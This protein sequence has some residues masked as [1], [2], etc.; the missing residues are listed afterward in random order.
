MEWPA[1]PDQFDSVMVAF[2]ANGAQVAS[3]EADA[4]LLH[5]RPE[6]AV[7]LMPASL[8]EDPVRVELA[9]SAAFSARVGV[10]SDG[11]LSL[12]LVQRGPLD[13]AADAVLEFD[14]TTVDFNELLTQQGVTS[15]PT[16]DLST[17][18]TISGCQAL[19]DSGGW[20]RRVDCLAYDSLGTGPAFVSVSTKFDYA[21]KSGGGRITAIAPNDEQCAGGSA[22]VSASIYRGTN[23]GSTPALGINHLT[24]TWNPGFPSS[25]GY[26]HN[27]Y[28][29]GSVWSSL[30]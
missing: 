3:L 30:T 27:I 6:L 7:E 15:G 23:V 14:S 4:N 12:S 11:T 9:E 2:G 25:R 19:S 26:N 5:E 8:T 16:G 17:L 24:C 22:S 28:A 1:S 18:G 29:Y 21:V 13:D 20:K 10:Y